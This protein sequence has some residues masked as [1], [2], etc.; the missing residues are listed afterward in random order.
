MLLE[1]KTCVKNLRKTIEVLR[2]QKCIIAHI[3]LGL[4]EDEISI[5]L[6]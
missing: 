4:K 6:S 2:F 1:V 3:K 5:M